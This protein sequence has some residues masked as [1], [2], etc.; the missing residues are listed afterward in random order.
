MDSI[1]KFSGIA[2]EYTKSRPGYA[3]EFIECLFEKYSFSS[4]SVVADIGSGTGKF[5]KQLLDKGCN[6]FCVEPNDDMRLVAE[7][8]LSSY[9][10]FKSVS[11]SAENTTLPGNFVDFITT[12]QAFHWFDTKSFKEECLRIIR[13][14][15][16]VLLI[17]NTRNNDSIINQELH[18]VYLQYCPDFKGFSGGTKL[19]DD[20]IKDFFNNNY[21]YITFENP[22]YFDREK[23]VNRSLSGSYSLKK[24]DK[25]FDLYIDEINRI[26]DE[27]ENDGIVKIEN[28]TVAY[29][30]TIEK[31]VN[32]D[33]LW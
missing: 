7:N 22:L 20:R 21:E 32:G 19:H 24:G 26:F 23:F 3:H 30:G 18:K 14:G 12:A 5:A 25:N 9:P 2:N 1:K 8:E 27:H 13:P 29:A 4:S 10:N 28:Q 11:G 6:V 33:L 15:G 16:K 31:D 17:W